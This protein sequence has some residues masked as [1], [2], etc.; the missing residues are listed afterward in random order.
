MSDVTDRKRH[1][2]L[3]LKGLG[4]DTY[5][6]HVIYMSR[7]CHVC[8]SIGSEVGAC[9]VVSL[10]GKSIVVH[11]LCKLGPHCCRRRKLS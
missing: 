3:H 10:A 11:R 5:R 2:H 7:D 9:A 8:R 6:E 1:S 4:I